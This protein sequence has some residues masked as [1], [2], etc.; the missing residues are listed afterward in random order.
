MSGR[1]QAAAGRVAAR[2]WRATAA[3]HVAAP[4][5]ALAPC[6]RAIGS[7]TSAPRRQAGAQA[8]VTT[9]QVQPVRG[10]LHSAGLSAV[11]DEMAEESHAARART[12]ELG[13]YRSCASR[14]EY[15]SYMLAHY[16]LYTALERT[17]AQQPADSPAARVWGACPGLHG[18]ARKLGRDLREAGVDA[19]VATPS[20]AAAACVAAVEDAAAN[21]AELLGHFYGRY[22]HLADLEGRGP[23]RSAA[24][25]LAIGLPERRPEFYELPPEIEDDREAYA[26][27]VRAA[28]D[29]E[30]AHMGPEDWEKAAK[31]A[32]AA[33]EL[34]ASICD[35]L[36]R[37]RFAK[38]ALGIVGVMRGYVAE[39]L[40]G[41]QFGHPAEVAAKEEDLQAVLGA[42]APPTASRELGPG[43]PGA[44]GGWRHA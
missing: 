21:G 2:C 1:L 34:S 4:A 43:S 15:V 35:E 27:D 8:L 40:C 30:G 17:L 25:R 11:L 42:T 18:F 6:V 5:A 13:F 37:L 3:P 7:A 44:C 20:P 19:S 10:G 26:D 38:A 36:P 14:Q 16:F 33:V 22:L 39:K 32:R 41:P 29:L 9:L 24:A 12:F 31:G 28:V 23:G